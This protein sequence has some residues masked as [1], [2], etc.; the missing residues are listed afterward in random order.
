ML[1]LPFWTLPDPRFP[2]DPPPVPSAS[3]LFGDDWPS[4]ATPGRPRPWSGW[5]RWEIWE[6]TGWNG[7]ISVS[8]HGNHWE[9]LG[10]SGDFVWIRYFFRGFELQ[11]YCQC[12]CRFCN[13]ALQSKNQK[14]PSFWHCRAATARLW[15]FG[16]EFPSKMPTY[17]GLVN[18]MPTICNLSNQKCVL[19][20]YIHIITI[21]IP[22]K[23]VCLREKSCMDLDASWCFL[24]DDLRAMSSL[25]RVSCPLRLSVHRLRPLVA[26]IPPA[27]LAPLPPKNL[28]ISILYASINI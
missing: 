28:C 14:S 21:G 6:L 8:K 22:Q 24:P 18:S 9:S 20:I 4:P 3:R 1:K 16:G 5:K 11:T 13:Y 27:S 19:Y 23:N 15:D 7:K 2:P 26:G 12:L 17:W 25:C 10:F